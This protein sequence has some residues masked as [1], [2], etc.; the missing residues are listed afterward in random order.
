MSTNSESSHCCPCR[1]RLQWP[2]AAPVRLPACPPLAAK[3]RRRPPLAA[4]PQVVA[5]VI[6]QFI[7]AY[8]VRDW[9]WWKLWIA[10]YV[11]SGTLNQNL[12]CAQ[13]SGGGARWGPIRSSNSRTPRQLCRGSTCFCF[14]AA[15]RQAPP[16]F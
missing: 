14:A 10:A 13:V 7:M 4:R 2:A 16:P 12:F 5:V 1:C 9:A 15:H 3:P 6:I 8:A 11:I